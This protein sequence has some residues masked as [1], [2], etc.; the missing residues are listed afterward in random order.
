MLKR[1]NGRLKQYSNRILASAVTIAGTCL[2]IVNHGDLNGT[3]YEK[4]AHPIGAICTLI[5]LYKI[6]PKKKNN[7]NNE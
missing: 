2:I 6:V 7:G 1:W 4:Y 5:T 3:V